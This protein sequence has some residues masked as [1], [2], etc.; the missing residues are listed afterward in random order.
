M[1]YLNYN[2]L[3]NI[4]HSVAPYRGSTNRFPT[5]LRRENRKYFLVGYEG[6]KTV[7][8]IVYGEHFVKRDITK[9]E[10]DEY[11]AQGKPTGRHTTNEYFTWDKASNVVGIVRSDNS[12]EFCGQHYYQGERDYLSK[13]SQGRFS[14]DSRRG[15][16]IYRHGDSIYP[17][18]RGMKV[19]CETMRPLDAD[20]VVVGKT[21]NRK[22]GKNL[23]KRYEDFYKVCEVMCKSMDGKAFEETAKSIYNEYKPEG[24]DLIKPELAF[25]L[26]DS[27]VD[28]AP[29]DALILYALALDIQN[30]SWMVRHGNYH[31]IITS[32]M[33]DLIKRVLNKHLYMKND[34]VFNPV[35]Y[36]MG[37]HLPASVWGYTITVGGKEVELY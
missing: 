19:D 20:V 28:Q 9:E 35:Y 4:A 5:G 15:G 22:E 24:E 26:A 21:V 6:D 3:L 2:R 29:F 13:C 18:Y 25:K 10:Y 27:L 31:Q 36:K 17:I 1:R 12:F 7:F 11:L 37:E 16:V 8:N 14:S 23:L 32:A 33:F 34:E 30:I